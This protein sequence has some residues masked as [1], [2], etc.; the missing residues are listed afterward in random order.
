M[1]KTKR[2]NLDSPTADFLQPRAPKDFRSSFP[3]RIFRIMSEFVDGWQF[4][5][6]FHK[7]VT[8]FGSARTP[9][10][11][12]WYKEARNLGEILAKNK[13]SMVTG[14]G[15]GIM[16]AANRGTYEKGGDSIGLDIKLPFEQRENPYVSKSIGFYHFFVRKVMLAYSARAYVFFPGGYGT[17]D[18]LFEMLTLLQ[19]KKIT[20]NIPVILVGKDF[21]EP[22]VKW[23][24]ECIIKKYQT[25][26]P[27]DIHIFSLVD[28][29]EEAFKIIKKAPERYEFD[30]YVTHNKMHT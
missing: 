28:T 22:L 16:E 10:D 4:L 19:T 24:E 29:A 8:V 17:L 11:D 30:E 14:G 21:W 5:A 6:D 12:R 18:E 9:E 1:Q 13:F 27:E 20:K 26:S 3:W 25:A 15:P 7:T 2:E 23:I